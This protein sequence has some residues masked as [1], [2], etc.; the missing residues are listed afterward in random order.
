MPQP[1]AVQLFGTGA[2]ISGGNLTVPLSGLSDTGLS[3]TDPIGVFA[4]I[5]KKAA[6]W[7]NTNTDEVVKA[8]VIVT[9]FAPSTRGDGTYTQF[10]YALNFFDTYVSPDFNPTNL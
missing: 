7:L 5:V 3:D 1:T 4:A 9:V 2:T 8:T 6:G 10:T